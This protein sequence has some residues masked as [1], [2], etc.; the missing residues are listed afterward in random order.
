M[1]QTVYIV[2]IASSIIVAGLLWRRNQR[3]VFANPD[4]A[5]IVGLSAFF[6]AMIGA[7]LPYLLGMETWDANAWWMSLDGKSILGGIFGAYLAVEIV[8]WINRITV[9][10]GDS[11]AIPVCAAVCIG[12][13]GCF[14]GGCCFGTTTDVPWACEFSKAG[15]PAGVLRHPVQLYEAIFHGIALVLLLLAQ[16][17]H[18][19]NGHR[20]KAYL[21]SYLLFRFVTEHIRPHPVRWFEHLTDYQ[22]ACIILAVCLI[23]LWIRD[24]NRTSGSIA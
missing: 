13:I 18:W 10:T 21:L 12:R 16:R 19:L 9:S 7:K 14:F 15:D 22:F 23:G 17:W 4:H 8:K 1:Y 24:A 3:T 5:R 6:G 11:F 2:C 20:L